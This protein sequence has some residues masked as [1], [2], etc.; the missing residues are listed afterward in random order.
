MK[1]KHT[2]FIQRPVEEVF[3][4]VANLANET[5]WQ[6]EIQSVTLEGPLQEGSTFREVRTTWGRRYEWHF[7]ITEFAPPHCITIATISGTLP[8]Q[9]SRIFTAVPGGTQVTEEGELQTRG[10]LRLLDPFLERLARRPLAVAYQNL[11]HLL[12]YG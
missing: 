8:Y 5:R 9:G 3:A 7:R 12:E 1:V 6:P 2:V 4:F 11:T 10:W